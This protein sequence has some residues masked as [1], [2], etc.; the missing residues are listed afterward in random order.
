MTPDQ[1][2]ALAWQKQNGLLPAIVQ[3]AD[4]LQVVM[5]G[6]MNREALESTLASGQVC[7]F[8]RSKNRLWTKG[9]SSG[10]YLHLVSVQTD[11]DSDTLLVLAH[12]QGPTCHLQRSSCFADAPEH[13]LSVLEKRIADRKNADPATS[14]SKR[15]MDS[16]LD[17]VAQ[18][19][20][21]E[22]VE[23]VIAALAQ[24]REALLGESADLL[25]HL[26]VLL[27]CKELTLAEVVDV[28]KQR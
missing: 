3:D 8:S 18:K 20:G 25:Y 12:P 14:Y 21:E 22:A 6:Y 4:S 1:I 24:N 16:G 27:Q 19:V 28:L 2:N 13:F 11:C 7:F 10:H 15:L 26:L 5:L 23:T 9:E 17:K